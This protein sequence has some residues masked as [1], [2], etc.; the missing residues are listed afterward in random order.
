MVEARQHLLVTTLAGAVG[1]F[2]GFVLSER[3][4]RLVARTGDTSY[5]A[6]LLPIA[7][8]GAVVAATL[9]LVLL[10][11]ER[12]LS[13]RPWFSIDLA[14]APAGSALL[15]ALGG[16]AAQTFFWYGQTWLADPVKAMLPAWIATRFSFVLLVFFRSVGWMLLG[17]G[18]GLMLGLA[19]RSVTQSVR[20]AMG[21]AAGGF[22]GGA[23]FDTVCVGIRFG[24][25]DD[26]WIAR[27]V[28]LVLTGAAIGFMMQVLAQTRFAERLLAAVN[29]A[30]LND[31]PEA[32]GASIG[33]ADRELRSGAGRGGDGSVTHTLGVPSAPCTIPPDDF[34]G[35]GRVPPYRLERDGPKP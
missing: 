9:G 17:A 16:G 25:N 1:G 7:V 20:G 18:T 13:G 4:I 31:L 33:F 12:H 35:Q 11:T 29:L 27:M 28:G 5:L 10:V 22:L 26:G 34:L 21:G 2:L 19:T 23:L 24:Q 30:H 32:G 14:W 3:A 8:W 6:L 15:G